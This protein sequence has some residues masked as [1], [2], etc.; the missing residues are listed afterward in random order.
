MPLTVK[1]RSLLKAGKMTD[2]TAPISRP[3]GTAR[4]APG[5]GV[6]PAGT[7]RDVPVFLDH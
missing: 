5:L 3:A 2:D 4:D 6:L 7:G 1:M